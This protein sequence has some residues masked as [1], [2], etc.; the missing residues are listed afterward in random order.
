ME[1]T[2]IVKARDRNSY[3]QFYR[4]GTRWHDND[5]YGHINNVIYYSYFDTAVNR[6]LVKNCGLVIGESRI[7]GYVV[8]SSCDYF[9]SCAYPEELEVGLRVNNIGT[10]SVEYGLGI[11]KL[12]E[13]QALAAGRFTHVFVDRNKGKSSK[14]PEEVRAGLK[15]LLIT[16]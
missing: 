15:K 8:S 16:E 9:D 12:G 10:T 3:I 5:I 4:Q 14:I 1:M 6:Y 2:D 11:F 13:N 7:V